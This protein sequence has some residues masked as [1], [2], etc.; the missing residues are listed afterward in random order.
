MNIFNYFE[1]IV[2]AISSDM[3]SNSARGDSSPLSAVSVQIPRDPN[4]GD[5][6]TNAALVLAKVAKKN[7]R[8]LA[9]RL[10]TELCKHNDI[11]TADIAGPGFI[12]LTMKA[13]FWHSVLDNILTEQKSYG[14]STLGAGQK[15][16]VEYVSTNPTG[17]IHV[18]HCR[19]AVFGDSLANL[20]E[21]AGFNVCREYYV[22][23]AGAQ[24][25]VLAQSAFLRYREALGSDVEEIPDGWYPGDYLKSVGQALADQHGDALLL[26]DE[27]EWMPVVR[28]YAIDA[29][30]DRI[31][32]DLQALG[33]KHDIF[34]SEK[35]L[36]DNKEIDLAL[37]RLDSQG[38]VYTGVLPPPKG[39]KP[40]DWEARPQVLFRATAFGD[41][42]DRPLQKSDGSWTYFAS[43][44]AYHYNKYSRNADILINVL[45]AEHGGYVKRME[46]AVTAITDGKAKLDVKLVQIVNLSKNGQ[47]LK[48]S[49]RAGTFVTIKDLVDEVGRDVTRFIMLTRRN[50]DTLDFD[51][52]RVLEQTKDNPVFY[53]QYAHARAKSVIR[54]ELENNPLVLN[55]KPDL[56]LLSRSEEISLI[57][58]LANWPRLVDQAAAAHEPHRVAFFL[59]DLAASVHRYWS[60]GK[61]DA[62]LRIRVGDHSLTRARLAL[63]EA[64]S[65][66]IANGLFIMGVT[67][68]DE[69]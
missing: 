38:L 45:G 27:A 55:E 60:R 1:G 7:P 17:P 24:V 34:F 20:L 33:I 65:I 39:K 18:G 51:F 61:E 25:D 23:D 21:F 22:N 26:Q 13:A 56:S 41:D 36:H 69:M 10:V 3:I 62:S 35:L 43:D 58:I 64:V 53:V 68:L 28:A 52:T 44:I 29:M 31:R 57:K 54:A 8:D 2:K 6:A 30:M 19:G 5:M 49:K 67:P 4:H 40:D 37:K 66:V 46:A 42:V 32:E 11:E 15:V 50:N 14:R 12:N 63:A 59:N 9:E 48:M 47:Q 16:N